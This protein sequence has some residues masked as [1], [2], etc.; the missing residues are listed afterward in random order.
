VAKFVGQEDEVFNVI[1]IK[2]TN[3]LLI[4]LLKF[5]IKYD[6]L[7]YNKNKMIEYKLND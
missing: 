7:F 4:F 5:S 6:A 3:F 2:K 1:I